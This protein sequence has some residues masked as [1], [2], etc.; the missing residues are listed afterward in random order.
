MK[1]YLGFIIPSAIIFTGIGSIVANVLFWTRGD[2]K[3]FLDYTILLSVNPDNFYAMM[4]SHTQ[5]TVNAAHAI[6]LLTI[7]VI[8]ISA[9]ILIMHKS[10]TVIQLRV[11]AF[12]AV[13]L[14]LLKPI[15]WATLTTFFL[16]EW[17]SSTEL[18]QD[19]YMAFV[20]G[21]NPTNYKDFLSFWTVGLLMAAL[22][23]AQIVWTFHIEDRPEVVERRAALG[24]E[25]AAQ[26]AVPVAPKPV[27]SAPA[28]P[29]SAPAVTTPPQQ[30]SGELS[31]LTKLHESGALTD[32]EFTAAK[33]RILGL[34]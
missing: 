6:F 5:A 8:I 24:R 16:S 34:K 18:Q 20:I 3:L 25:K 26:R 28:K 27:Q 12:V 17:V 4:D 13:F 30:L 2:F 32:E 11:L 21:G 23:A 29:V 22:L 14:F 19:A 15:V 7:L 33:N 1:K 10:L 9:L 31:A